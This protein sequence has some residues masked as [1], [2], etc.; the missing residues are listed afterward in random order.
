M[1]LETLTT[2]FQRH[3][4]RPPRDP[5]PEN[6]AWVHVD[7]AAHGFGARQARQRCWKG[8][9]GLSRGGGCPPSRVEGHFPAQISRGP[10]FSGHGHLFQSREISDL[11]ASHAF[12][13]LETRT[14]SSDIPFQGILQRK[15][16]RVCEWVSS[17]FCRQ[18][19][20][21]SAHWN[22]YVCKISEPKRTFFF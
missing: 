10:G 19:N 18:G 4:R 5:L 15:E 7:G 1:T 8:R 20:L 2:P 16:Q 17:V 11:E 22:I 6:V 13:T 12:H 3:C 14:V 9:P 21:S